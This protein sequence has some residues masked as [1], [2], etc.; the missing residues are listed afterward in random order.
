MYYL[1]H[2]S[3]VVDP[4]KGGEERGDRP[5]PQTRKTNYETDL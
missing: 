1:V 4:V 3:T 2:T 5:T